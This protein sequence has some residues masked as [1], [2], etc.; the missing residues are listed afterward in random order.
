MPAICRLIPLLFL[1]A[2]VRAEPPEESAERV[3]ERAIL[4]GDASALRSADV[5]LDESLRAH[6]D[7]PAL[8]YTRAFS[9]YAAGM[10]GA[11]ADPVSARKNLESAAAL[12]EKVKG[13]PWEAEANALEGGVLGQLISLKGGLSGM[14]LGPRSN[15]H[16]KRARE[17]E[18]ENPRVLLFS[19]LSLISTPKMWGGDVGEGEQMLRQSTERFASAKNEGD[20]P[21]W[22]RAL[23]W[24]WLGLA[25]QMTGNSTGAETAWRQALAI[26]PDFGWVKHRLQP[27]LNRQESVGKS[28]A[29]NDAI[30]A[31]FYPPEGRARNLGLLYLGGSEGGKPDAHEPQALAKMG[32]P[33]LAV[34][35]FGAAGLPETLELIPLEYFE[36][37]VAALQHDHGLN[38]DGVVVVGRS[39]GA[40]LALVLASSD[41]AIKGVVAISPSS[42]VW[43]GL[44]KEFWPPHP[45]SSWTLHGDPL[46]YVPYD[47]SGTFDES[48]PQ[49][50]YKVYQRSLAQKAVP[51][52]SV[53]PVEKI[54]GPILLLSGNDDA[55]WPSNQM[56]ENI[57][58]RLTTGGFKFAVSHM[59][60]PE[61]GH[62]L[63]EDFPLGG[64]PDGNRRARID[65][66]R[67]ILAFL[68]TIR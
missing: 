58:A 42:V 8:L 22:G 10:I 56:A 61:A 19:G 67:R 44:P 43:Q 17:L 32:Y 16:L 48:D 68:D 9:E 15:R 12:L 37:A 55:L 54:R 23:S 7:D 28:T 45:V 38:I 14:Q 65:S 21:H 5:S 39:K 62:T 59:N 20:R 26:E 50:I 1:I 63:N 2:C 4:V 51:A 18:P 30:A 3:I 27:A 35:Y 25:A 53:I 11:K 40:E 57:V 13:G 33:V 41:L 31:D 66:S 47:Y 52:E 34:A 24:A 64:T 36:R 60:Y 6:P 49:A 29:G 46:P